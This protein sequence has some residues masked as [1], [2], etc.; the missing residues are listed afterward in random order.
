MGRSAQKGGRRGRRPP[1]GE[2]H[3]GR[4]LRL[5]I[6]LLLGNNNHHILLPQNLLQLEV[7]RVVEG[8]PQ[9]LRRADQLLG[10][11]EKVVDRH[12]PLEDVEVLLRF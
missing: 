1:L 12:L 5:L 6:P 4:R 2:S 10:V 3:R 7:Q 8:D 9:L 11:K